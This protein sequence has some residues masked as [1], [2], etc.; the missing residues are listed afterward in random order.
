[1]GGGG[2]PLEAFLHQHLLHCGRILLA[3][4]CPAVEGRSDACRTVPAI[5]LSASS[6]R[7]TSYVECY[8]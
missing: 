7:W 5:Q 1:M 4:S 3:I 2:M 6:Y 8:G